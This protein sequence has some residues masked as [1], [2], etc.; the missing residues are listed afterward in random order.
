MI[1]AQGLVKRYGPFEAVKGVS[2]RV[3]TGQVIGLLGPNG[4]GK[5]SIMRI[6]TAFHFPTAGTA[7]IDGHDVLAE[8]HRVRQVIGYLP[9]NAPAYDDMKVREYL[10]F[11]AR[12]RGLSPAARRERLSF[13]VGACGLAEVFSR[14][15]RRLSKGYRQRVGLA[16]A[17]LH[18]PGVLILD[19]PTSGLDPNQ[20][21]EIRALIRDLGRQKTVL[22]STHILQEVEA[23]CRRVLIMA[24]GR[25]IAQGTPQEIARGMQEAVLL[26][27]SLKAPVE[28]SALGALA[29]LPGVRSVSDPRHMSG[30]R[31]EVDLEVAAGTDP[32]EA[33]YDWAVAS[34]CKILGMKTETAKL[35]ELFA[36]LTAA[37]REGGGV[38]R[39]GERRD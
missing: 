22:L 3:E 9:E 27:V 37:D 11:I 2:F 18:D 38:S 32:S 30:D 6:L 35:E 29:S 28:P 39:E 31:L 5:T 23:L 25:L 26:V 8:P 14:E 16:Q 7:R 10:E 20:I 1:E 24:G 17:I 13:V 33:V 34:G 21:V 19:E 4:A 12:V 36:R 15:V